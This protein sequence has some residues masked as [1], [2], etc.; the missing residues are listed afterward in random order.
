MNMNIAGDQVKEA[1]ETER[2]FFL[3]LVGE[4]AV[5]Y[6]FIRGTSCNNPLKEHISAPP[7]E[8]G[9]N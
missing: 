9:P 1:G 4:K 3:L 6:G 7:Y 5:V 8:G 2:H